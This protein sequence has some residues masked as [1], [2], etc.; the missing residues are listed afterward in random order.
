MKTPL[1]TGQRPALWL[2]MPL[3]LRSASAV[4]PVLA[5]LADVITADTCT[6]D[7]A[8]DK[9]RDSGGPLG[10]SNDCCAGTDLLACVDG[11]YVR[12]TDEC[13]SSNTFCTLGGCRCHSFE[14][15]RPECGPGEYVSNEG[16][17]GCSDCPAGRYQPSERNVGGEEESCLPCGQSGQHQPIAGQAQCVECTPGQYQNEPAREHCISCDP[18]HVQPRHGAAN[19]SAC[20]PGTY[21]AEDSTLCNACARG[22]VQPDRGA[23]NASLCV[24]CPSGKYDS[25]D[26]TEVCV[27]CEFGKTT[28]MPTPPATGAVKCIDCTDAVADLD[29][30]EVSTA[31]SE[32]QEAGIAVVGV[33]LIIVPPVVVCI[34]VMW[35]FRA[36]I[37]ERF[38][39]TDQSL[40][41][42]ATQAVL[43]GSQDGGGG[44]GGDGAQTS[45]AAPGV[46]AAGG[47][48]GG[49]PAGESAPEGGTE[50]G[51]GRDGGGPAD[52]ACTGREAAAGGSTADA[53][54]LAASP[55]HMGIGAFGQDAANRAS[56]RKLNVRP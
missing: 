35:I 27:G 30:S 56:T 2:R 18:G 38:D 19:C 13:C 20:A 5:L 44:G 37:M 47:G 29:G 34:L 32:V 46:G 53:A 51:T 45:A 54:K 1:N 17:P 33:V 39:R 48:G 11:Y 6:S 26:G 55:Q 21:A 50:G 28:P 3:V 22:T 16:E 14:C 25:D 52:G 4:L 7:P 49:G 43:N 40:E 36:K 10:Q 42:V 41:F 8:E 31:C 15:C 23:R 24:A 12:P 9:C